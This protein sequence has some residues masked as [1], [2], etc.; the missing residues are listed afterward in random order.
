AEGTLYIADRGEHRIRKVS[1]ANGTNST[2]AG[3]KFGSGSG[4]FGFVTYLGGF[5]GD[6]G[7]ATSAILND[8]DGIAVDAAG[9]VY[10]SDT[11][12]YRIRRIDAITGVIQTIAGTG[13]KGFSGDGGS[14]LS[15][16]ITTPSVLIADP[17]GH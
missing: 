10:I 17:A 1:G 15:A 14:A 11:L 3:A 5:S 16:Q 7:P 6:A 2:I 12:N 8:P 13:V 4:F 9:N